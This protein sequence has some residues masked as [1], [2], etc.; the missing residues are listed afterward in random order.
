MK[1][2]FMSTLKTQVL[3]FNNDRCHHLASLSLFISSSSCY[4]SVFTWPACLYS[5]CRGQRFLSQKQKH[6]FCEEQVVMLTSHHSSLTWFNVQRDSKVFIMSSHGSILYLYNIFMLFIIKLKHSRNGCIKCVLMYSQ[7]CSLIKTLI[8]KRRVYSIKER[9][10]S[11]IIPFMKHTA[12]KCK[13]GHVK[14]TC[15][16]HWVWIIRL[17][18]CFLKKLR[19]NLTERFKHLRLLIQTVPCNIIIVL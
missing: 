18:Q 14:W 17:I 5:C 16:K 3:H 8:P 1:G 2:S 13:D 19:E 15:V 7:A 12:L 11:A 10:H 6:V 4:F 9:I